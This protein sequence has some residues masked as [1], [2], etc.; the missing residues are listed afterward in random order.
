[1]NNQNKPN[2]QR[3]PSKEETSLQLAKPLNFCSQETSNFSITKHSNKKT[4]KF[5]K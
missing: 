3:E 5:G 2:N 1:M 4:L